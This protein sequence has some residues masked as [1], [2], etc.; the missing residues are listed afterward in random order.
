MKITYSP[1]TAFRDDLEREVAVYF[2]NARIASHGG[3]AMY[4]KTTVLLLWLAA[5]YVALV[6]LATTA[7]QA[8][9]LA[10][11]LGAVMAFVGFNISHDGGHR[12]Y[13]P[14]PSL[15]RVM[16]FALDLLGGSSYF[17]RFRH[18]IG[19]HT[20]PNISGHDDDIYVGPLAR[21]SPND[22][23]YWFHRYQHVYI[24]TLYA[25]YSLKWQLF[26][27]FRHIVMLR[28]QSTKVPRLPLG[29]QVAFWSGKLI[30]FGLALGVP[31]YYHAA[32]NVLALYVITN[33]SLGLILSA[34][35]QLAHSV[36]DVDFAPV[37]EG[38]MLSRDWATY[39]V[40]STANF[41]T[42]GFLSWLLGGL[43]FQIEHHLF[44]QVSH[45]H[46]PALT[47]IVE[48]VC[49]RHGVRYFAHPSFWTAVVCHCQWLKYLGR[50]DH[51]ASMTWEPSTTTCSPS[52][53]VAGGR[54]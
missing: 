15:N 8:V 9:L 17:W 32:D 14:N 37:P 39:Q 7:W 45:V 30:F 50:A 24:W 13:S 41:R 23:R 21:L 27:D 1:R 40:E 11:V 54:G 4:V 5:T 20:Y 38:G 18:N 25:V 10:I 19:H 34:V 6:F 16:A 48:R 43:N 33:M 2:D 42:H 12:S 29:E 28:I 51:S 35:F 3:L 47:P 49:Q 52:Q 44:P 53:V 46:Y 22:R 26:D 36:G 31:L